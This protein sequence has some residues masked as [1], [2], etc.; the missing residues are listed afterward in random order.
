M[1]QPPDWAKGHILV[2]PAAGLSDEA[3]AKVLAKRGGRSVSHN[4]RINLHI[5]AVPP[6]AEEAVAKALAKNPLIAFAEPDRLVEPSAVT[7][8]DPQFPS[9]WHLERIQAPTA[10]EMSVGSNITVAVLDT[11]IDPHN[12]ELAS[13][14][15]PGW[16]S[17]SLNNDTAPTNTHGTLIAGIVAAETN[18]GTGV[19]S[20]AYNA[21]LMPIRV[22]NS[23][24]GYAYESDIAR[25]L[26][27]AADH[28]ALVANV[29][30]DVTTSGAVSSAAQYMRSMGG[31]V[32]VPAGNIGH[33]P[34]YSNNPYMISVSATTISDTKVTYSGY[35]EYIDVAAPGDS[36]ITTRVG[37]YIQ[38]VSGTSYASPVAAGVAA[39]IMATNSA[40]S[41]SDVESLL[42]STAD[43]LGT[44]GR[45]P[46]FGF[47]RVNAAAAVQAAADMIPSDTQAPE[48]S[49]TSP[50]AESVATGLV[51][52]AVNAVDDTAVTRVELHADGTLVGTD[53]T[54]PYE[55]SWDSSLSGDGAT[56]LTARAF[57]EA[58]NSGDAA[59][60]TVTVD[61]TA[62]TVV[63]LS[64]K[65][66]AVVRGNVPLSAH[67]SEAVDLAQLAIYVDGQAMCEG[68]TATVSCNWKTLNLM[69]NHTITARAVDGAGN[70]SS[71]IASVTLRGNA[72]E[73]VTK[74]IQVSNANK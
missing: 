34:G 39:L 35:G 16:N 13:R 50:T 61:N 2:Q 45:D 68:N 9:E 62:P 20:V 1:A 18:N 57:D 3:L 27:W 46:Y 64:P 42:E 67:A 21:R 52:V 56:T 17:V 73:H 51:P 63:I 70:A 31:V 43:D 41:P 7:P 8:D 54:E 74:A 49:I 12:A 14:L 28:G 65:D 59:P 66:G 24:D 71:A 26:T 48:A 22:T 4:Q 47:G 25:G 29:G 72:A 15:V 58:G 10:W 6:Q 5:V 23:G 38:T 11:G 44:A 33:D 69:G 60:V 32:V 36:I 30:Y 53:L 19:A 40:L 55:F 37:G